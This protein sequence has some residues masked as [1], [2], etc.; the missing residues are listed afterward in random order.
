MAIKTGIA[1]GMNGK[2]FHVDIAGKRFYVGK[3]RPQA[4]ERKARLLKLWGIAER[5]KRLACHDPI[6]SGAEVA[7]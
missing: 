1:G 5:F 6:R 3:D 2:P 7:A 4:E